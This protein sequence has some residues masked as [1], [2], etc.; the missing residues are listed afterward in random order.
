MV[1][2]FREATPNN[3]LG[4]YF[5]RDFRNIRKVDIGIRHGI[6]SFQVSTRFP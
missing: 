3:A 6:Q 4:K 1:D 2:T 5:R